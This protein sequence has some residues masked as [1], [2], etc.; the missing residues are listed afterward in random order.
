[1]MKERSSSS[2]ENIG[3]KKRRET[4]VALGV[5]TRNFFPKNDG[6][7]TLQRKN[8]QRCLSEGNH[9]NF[10]ETYVKGL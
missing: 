5:K 9:S 7:E 8:F 6:K 3:S 2:E 4:C 10:E 1:M